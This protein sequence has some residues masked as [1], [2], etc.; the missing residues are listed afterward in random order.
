MKFSLDE[1][2]RER[3]DDASKKKN[4]ARSKLVEKAI[5]NMVRQLDPGPA[6]KYVNEI[7]EILN[8][9]VATAQSS[10]DFELLQALAQ[11]GHDFEPYVAMCE[12]KPVS[13]PGP[14]GEQSSGRAASVRRWGGGR[15]YL[16]S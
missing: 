7:H 14:L 15:G 8:K 5:E 13:P 3:L 16:D 1:G 12:I 11:M 4:I 10:G 2:T 9:G 6:C